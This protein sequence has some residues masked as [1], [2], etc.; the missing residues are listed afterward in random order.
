MFDLL[1]LLTITIRDD[2]APMVKEDN[3]DEMMV[4]IIMA[5]MMI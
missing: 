5:I 3:Y 4:A 1:V 2:E